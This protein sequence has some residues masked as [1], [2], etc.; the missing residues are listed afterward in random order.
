MIL[1]LTETQVEL[2]CESLLRSQGA[3]EALAVHAHNR[4][5]IEQFKSLARDCEAL[6]IELRTQ[7]DRSS[8]TP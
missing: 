6:L 8:A 5:N 4:N 2:I 7:A 1:N 3:Y